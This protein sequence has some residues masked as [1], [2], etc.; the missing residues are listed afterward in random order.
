MTVSGSQLHFALGA[1]PLPGLCG[2]GMIPPQPPVREKAAY[3]VMLRTCCTNTHMQVGVEARC[4]CEMNM[5]CACYLPA[6]QGLQNFPWRGEVGRLV[7]H[8]T[9]TRV[10]L[11]SPAEMCVRGAA[12]MV[13]RLYATRCKIRGLHRALSRVVRSSYKYT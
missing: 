5:R 10:P 4:E 6:Q 7:T 12:K 8:E 3:E 2:D 9:D 1:D 13:A 11:A